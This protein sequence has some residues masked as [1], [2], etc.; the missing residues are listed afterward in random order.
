MPTDIRA[1]LSNLNTSAQK[2]RLVIDLVRGQPVLEALDILTFTPKK[3]AVPV[4][5]LLWS[6]IANA[7]ENFGVSRNDLYIYQIYADEAPTRKWRRF[8]AR[9][10]FKP[11]LRRR[12]H[13]T[14]VLREVE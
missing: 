4:Q 5:K 8:G 3:A 14:V 13:I 12:S 11:I 9:G 6:A 7:E 10:R 2:A 1:K